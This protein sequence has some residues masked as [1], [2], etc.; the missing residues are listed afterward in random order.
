M[1][2]RERRD[3]V[4]L[5]VVD[6]AG[7]RAHLLD[8]TVGDLPDLIGP[9][10]LLVLNDAATLPASLSGRGHSG[11]PPRAPAGRAA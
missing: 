1:T 4:R 5:L 6:A 8:R 7:A 10:D 9:G 11:D 2:G 3:D